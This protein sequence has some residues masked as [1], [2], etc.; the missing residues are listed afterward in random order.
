MEEFTENFNNI[1][2]LDIISFSYDE[3]K[4]IGYKS[5]RFKNSN[6]SRI[7]ANFYAAKA[8]EKILTNFG[9]NCDTSFSLQ[10]IPSIIEKWD[11]AEVFVNHCCV[12]V[13]YNFDDYKL[14]IPQKHERYGLLGDIIMFV[15]FENNMVKLLGFLP[16]EE[17]DRTNSDNENYYI[18][19]ESLK[20]FDEIDFYVTKSPENLETLKKEKIKII[21]YLD[22][23]IEDKIEF[24]KLLSR[25]E[26]LREEM[27]KFEHAA[28]VYSALVEKEDAIKEEINRN[29]ANVSQL[30]DAFIQSKAQIINIGEQQKTADNFKLECARANLEKLFNSSDS[31]AEIMEDIHNKS[32]SEVVDTLLIKS[33]IV[34]QGERLP[35]GAILRAFKVFVFLLIT[36]LITAGIFCYTNYNKY[37]TKYHTPELIQQI[38]KTFW[39]IPE[40]LKKN[41]VS[42]YNLFDKL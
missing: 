38:Q 4:E 37:D 39:N 34:R 30:A 14:Y 23:T 22:G 12:S 13:R 16:V 3:L 5:S 42:L 21:K 32:I 27:I 7:I 36:M 41:K 6:K 18:D 17:L 33:D 35:I 19:K 1:K 2:P 20:S 28:S 31:N 11:V 25:S 9:L 8:A 24:F 29:A 40:L 10:E 15:R 26:Y